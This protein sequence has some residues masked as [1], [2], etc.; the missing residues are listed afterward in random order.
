MNESGYQVESDIKEF[1]AF[2]SK[3][4]YFSDFDKK[5]FSRFVYKAVVISRKEIEFE[6]KFGLK[7]R[8]RL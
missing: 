3:S 6:F 7:L 2:L 4:K 8:E 1:I 5:L